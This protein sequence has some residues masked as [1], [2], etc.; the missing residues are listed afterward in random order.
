MEFNIKSYLFQRNASSQKRDS[1]V[2]VKKKHFEPDKKLNSNLFSINSLS[3]F[4]K[5]IQYFYTN[6]RNS[7]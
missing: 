2:L 7:M 5:F 3:V 4:I 6:T 1:T